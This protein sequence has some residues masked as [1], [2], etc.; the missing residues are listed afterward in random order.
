MLKSYGMKDE[1]LPATVF[2]HGW[3]KMGEEK[4][5]KSK[6]NVVDPIELVNKYGVDPV[7]YF[8]LK[9]IRF[10]MDGAFTEDALTTVYNTDLANDMGNLLNRTLTMVDKYFEGIAPEAPADP[11]DEAQV[12]RSGD[13]KDAVLKVLPK[14]RDCLTSKEL[15]MKEA[16][17]AIMFAVGKANKYI[18]ESAPWTYSKE[19]N[20]EAIKLILADLL[21]VLRKT[22]RAIRS[23][24]PET[25]E[26]MWRQLG[27]AE[28]LDAG[29]AE[30]T[31]NDA[32]AGGSDWR[33]FPAGTKVAKGEP[34]F[35]RIEK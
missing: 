27:L 2:A 8:L 31:E 12:K 18:E 29:L 20:I 1:E 15:M 4:M 22:A 3:W 10:G 33:K 5:S 11:G 24:M 9:A 6:G 23:F 7:R 14:T 19:G 17:E 26:K 30:E 32:D 13:V 25:A 28:D 34:L 35:P 21:E 16:L